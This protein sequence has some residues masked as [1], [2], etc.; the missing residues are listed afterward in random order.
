[1]S[2][3]V[4][5]NTVTIDRRDQMRRVG[6]FLWV[7]WA[8]ATGHSHSAPD[9]SCVDFFQGEHDG[10]R[11]LGVKHRRTVQRLA[12]AGWMILDDLLGAGEHDA[13]LHWL[14]ADLPF[15]FSDLPFH[16]SFTS[17]LGRIRW[18]MISGAKA[19]S[20]IVR[21][22]KSSSPE[23][24]GADTPLLGWESPT[25]GELRPAVSL[26]YRAHS[27]LPLRFATVIL[28]DERCRLDV[29]SN[30][31]IVRD[32]ESEIYRTDLNLAA[33]AHRLSPAKAPI[34]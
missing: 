29:E 5:H 3:T 16:V 14:V 28:T 19:E 15:V 12:R 2:R 30:R 20:A 8:Q 1:M 10:Y 9:R 11:R 33:G 31:L 27:E 6:R 13:R 24:T 25:Y 32:E 17:K 23:L 26:V 18:W 4:V 7:D 22:G 21:E 34:S